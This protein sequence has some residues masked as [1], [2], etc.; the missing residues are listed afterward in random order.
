MSAKDGFETSLLQHIMQNSALTGIGD[1]GGLLP[2]ATSGSFYVALYTTAPTD[3]TSGTEANY[4]GYAR[5]GVARNSGGWTVSGN[6]ASNTAAITFGQCSAGTNTLL[7]F[8]LCKAG[9]TGID[10][11]LLFGAIT[12]NL[13]VSTGIT[14][15]FAIGDLD[16]NLD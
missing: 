3:S 10:D 2:S 11:Q 9:T 7:A 8:A 15:E 1:A 13:S 6:N 14:P 16:I 5:V 12:P 4:T